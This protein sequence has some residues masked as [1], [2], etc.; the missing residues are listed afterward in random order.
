MFRCHVCG[1]NE[2]RDERVDE[3]FQIVGHPVLVQN[4][5]AHVCARC[6]EA[7]FSRQT[8]EQIRRMVHGQARPLRT[9]QMDVFA[10]G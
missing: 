9:V 7:V 3:L 1:N 10:F 4:I 5:P 2:Y 6:G 8:T